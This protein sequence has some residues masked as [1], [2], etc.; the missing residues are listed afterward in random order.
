MFDLA[1]AVEFEYE[2]GILQLVGFYDRA[3]EFG[4]PRDLGGAG[5][6]RPPREE[7]EAGFAVEIALAEFG[8][9]LTARSRGAFAVLAVLF[10]AEFWCGAFVSPA[11]LCGFALGGEFLRRIPPRWFALGAV[12][13]LAVFFGFA[14][15][16]ALTPAL[17][18]ETRGLAPLGVGLGRGLLLDTEAE[19]AIENNFAEDGE[20]ARA[21]ALGLFFGEHE[22]FFGGADQRLARLCLRGEGGGLGELVFEPKV[23]GEVGGTLLDF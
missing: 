4:P 23:G 17:R 2:A 15:C 14:P 7:R 20:E 3:V 5:G 16:G 8:V 6:E 10:G 9:G 18:S 11:E 22:K 21:P 12:A 1:A 19:I 13:A